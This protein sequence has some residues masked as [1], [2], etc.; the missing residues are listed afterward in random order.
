LRG[1]SPPVARR[2]LIAEQASLGELHAALQVAFGWSDEH[3]YA[4]QIRGWR[5]GDLARVLELALAGGGV[6][7]PLAAFEFEIGEPFSI[8]TT[9]SSPGKSS[10]GSK[11]E[12]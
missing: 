5:F 2:I 8:S 11:R 1:V 10:A 3:L 12:V 9:C 6:G 4:F 7:M